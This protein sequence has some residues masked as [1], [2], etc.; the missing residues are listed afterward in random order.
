MIN[1]IDSLLPLLLKDS[2]LNN[3]QQNLFIK[4]LKKIEHTNAEDRTSDEWFVLGYA[5]EAQGNDLK[6]SEYYTE[7]IKDNPDFEAAY[8]NRGA[9][10]T[11]MKEYD[12]ALFDLNK[13]IE[14][15]PDYLDAKLQL[16]VLY[17]DQD[18][19]DESKTVI[20][21]ILKKDS[22][23]LRA[24]AQLG[25]IYDKQDKYP[26]AINE[27]DIVIE[28]HSEDGN[29]YSQRAISKLFGGDAEGAVKDFQ[30]AQRYSGANY[31]TYFNLGLS[32][33]MMEN[34]SKQAY[35]QF[36]KA[37]RKQPTILASYFKEAKDG[38][39]GRLAKKIDEILA[40]LK[41]TDEN[42]PG[43]FYRDEL[44]DLLERKLSEAKNPDAK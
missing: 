13:A 27:Y 22:G 9:A 41:D 43:K 10:F 17:S 29:L 16:S 39:T 44:I 24:H 42:K 11:R 34:G 8:K 14:L 12:D 21:E 33:G 7:A 6:A 38:E 36:E 20:D 32:Y 2:K 37:F 15:D 35:Q 23:H 31:I 5:A 25:A 28:K 3:R 19:L 30:K 40:H 26:E 18:K 4:I 1:D